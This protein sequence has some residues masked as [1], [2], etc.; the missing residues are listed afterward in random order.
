MLYVGHKLLG[1][2]DCDS[3][4]IFRHFVKGKDNLT[5]K[6]EQL[7]VKYLRR[8]HNPILKAMPGNRLPKSISWL[9]SVN[10]DLKLK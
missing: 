8:A 9:D 5:L 6:N 10:L 4:K 7:T 3:P 1:F 2:Q